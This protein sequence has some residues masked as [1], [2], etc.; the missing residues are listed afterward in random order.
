MKRL[1]AL[2]MVMM[3][4]LVG[5]GKGQTEETGKESDSAASV[6]T[7]EQEEEDDEY[8]YRKVVED[9]A[10]TEGKMAVYYIAPTVSYDAWDGSTHAGDS[11]L[12]VTPDGKTLLY[13]CNTAI[14]SAY[15]VHFLQKL[16]IE[17]L[18]YYVN[19]HPDGDHIGGYKILLRHIDIGHVYTPPAETR[20]GFNTTT[21]H[22]GSP[23]S[24]TLIDDL[25]E[26]GVP[27]SYLQEGDTFQLGKEVTVKIYNPPVDYDYSNTSISVNEM[28][29]IMKLTYK[30]SSFL[31]TADAG[32]NAE[33]YG[34]ATFTELMNKYGE[35][36]HVDVSSM[37]HHANCYLQKGT[38]PKWLSTVNPKI[39]IGSMST[40]EDEERYFD[41]VAT[42]ALALHTGIDGTV[43]VSTTGD[44]TY[45]VQVEYDR[46]S[47]YYGE[48]ETENGHISVK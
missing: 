39:W 30:D 26:A 37:C 4:L 19:S 34:R 28:S 15:M 6:Q 27:H 36:L 21:P 12:Y 17:K 16:G 41:Y 18:D 23:A 2:L 11:V 32:N 8:A 13:D 43:V 33:E 44:G 10:L 9:R 22:L 14:N 29:I 48:L 3:L 47:S 38:D 7:D 24:H 5:C 35:E 31:S 46:I 1:I 45:D 42:G 20:Y 40:I 25:D